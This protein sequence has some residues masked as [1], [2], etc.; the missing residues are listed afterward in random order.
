MG[1]LI[2]IM[3]Y[4]AMIGVSVGTLYYMF[5]KDGPVS[6]SRVTT[7]MLLSLVWFVSLPLFI[8]LDIIDGLHD[9]KKK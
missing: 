5:R 7:I 9:K 2:F 3:G 6:D 8:V 4:S 1:F